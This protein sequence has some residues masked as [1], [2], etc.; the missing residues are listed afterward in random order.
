MTAAARRS[1]PRGC[2]AVRCEIII[3]AVLSLERVHLVLVARCAHSLDPRDDV[4]VVVGLIIDSLG[5]GVEQGS[6]LGLSSGV[7]VLARSL[8]VC[9][10]AVLSAYPLLTGSNGKGDVIE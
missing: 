7:V 10:L 3:V 5:L 1:L 8:L 9:Y 4:G 6:S 2:H